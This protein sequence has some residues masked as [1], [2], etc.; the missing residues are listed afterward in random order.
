MALA[1]KPTRPRNIA[2]DGNSCIAAS[3]PPRRRIGVVRRKQSLKIIGVG[4]KAVAALRVTSVQVADEVRRAGKSVFAQIGVV[5][6][7]LR[8]EAPA[9]VLV[10]AKPAITEKAAA[11]AVVGGSARRSRLGPGRRA[12]H[13][14]LAAFKS[15][16]VFALIDHALLGREPRN[17][18]RVSVRADRP[19][20][21]HLDLLP[22]FR[23]AGKTGWK[24]A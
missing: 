11:E 10:N 24:E 5:G 21:G 20:V 17:E 22:E 18:R 12:E 3:A 16:P 4:G 14:K 13:A 7:Q 15:L 6:R 1:E 2:P 23:G 8:A 19:I 9:P